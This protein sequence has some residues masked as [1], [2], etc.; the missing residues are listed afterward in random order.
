[1]DDSRDAVPACHSD[2]ADADEAQ[3]L[4]TTTG[5]SQAAETKTPQNLAAPGR[6]V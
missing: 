1:M 5:E 2:R 3:T 6:P 4:Q